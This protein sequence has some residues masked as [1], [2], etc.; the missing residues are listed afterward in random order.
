MLHP[1]A[2]P[3]EEGPWLNIAGFAW[4]IIAVTATFG[5]LAVGLFVMAA[6]ILFGHPPTR[7]WWDFAI[8]LGA[9][10]TATAYILLWVLGV[11]FIRRRAR[12]AKDKYAQQVPAWTRAT[13]K[14]KRLYY[15]KRDDIVFD[16]LDN[17]VCAPE[18][19]PEFLYAE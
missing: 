17:K 7:N 13:D 10:A 12:A 18:A 9:I 6:E 4:V 16:P 3:Y 11:R 14:Y 8:P 15:C 1:P 19:L 2:K 5:P